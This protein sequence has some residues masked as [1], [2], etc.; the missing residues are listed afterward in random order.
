MLRPIWQ[1]LFPFNWVF[2]LLLIFLLGIPRFIIALQA[3]VTGNYN[4]IT[5]IFIF[6]LFAPVI[7]LT[8]KGRREIGIKKPANYHWLLYS[9]LAGI[10]LCVIMF[11]AAELFFNETVRNWFVYISS[12]Y[13]APRT[14]LSGSE[15]L[16][17]FSIYALI[18]MTFSPVG[19]ELFYR[20]IVHGSFVDRYGEQKSSIIDSLA[21]SLTHLAHFGIIY[22]SGTWSFHFLPALL[23][24]FFMFMASRLFFLCKQ[25]TGSILGAV[26]CHASYNLTMMYFIFYH[27]LK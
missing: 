18:G 12:S 24:V 5:F 4:L 16:I 13:K 2:G 1:N 21:F 25:K 22:N 15:R 6:M 11:I 20:G 23:W 19:E 26:F 17:F 10:A 27:I 3:N 8:K 14:G 7:F 9:F